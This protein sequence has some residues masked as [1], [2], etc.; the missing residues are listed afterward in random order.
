M[1]K[2][3]VE[4]ASGSEFRSL[5][6]SL[7]LMRECAWYEPRTLAESDREADPGEPGLCSGQQ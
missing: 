3:L 6:P 4:Q 1:D 7:S 2:G 5:E